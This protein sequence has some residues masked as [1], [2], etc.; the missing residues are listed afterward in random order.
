MFLKIE[1]INLLT[2]ALISYSHSIDSSLNRTFSS[3]GVRL[4]SKYPAGL[5][6]DQ[7]LTE[8][9]KSDVNHRPARG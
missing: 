8:I 1:E 4:C 3:L 2:N 7:L 5:S 9:L 6:K